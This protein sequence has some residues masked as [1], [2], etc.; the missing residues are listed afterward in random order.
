MFTMD[1]S[2]YYKGSLNLHSLQIPPPPGHLP[3]SLSPLQECDALTDTCPSCN[4]LCQIKKLY[5]SLGEL[6][7]T[8]P[9]PEEELEEREDDDFREEKETG[10]H[11]MI[12]SHSEF[13]VGSHLK[14]ICFCGYHSSKLAQ[15]LCS[16]KAG[17]NFW[18]KH[19][20]IKVNLGPRSKCA[21][22]KS[23]SNMNILTN[24]VKSV[25]YMTITLHE[26]GS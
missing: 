22:S 26:M 7:Q 24:Y 14:K 23:A 12:R 8:I 4:L 5:E 16:T 15:K 17:Y 13:L 21:M 10:R 11:A 3:P 19:P 1:L 9:E 20:A 6:L 25:L 2:N 18:R